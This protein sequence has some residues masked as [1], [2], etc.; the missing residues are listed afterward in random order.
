MIIKTKHTLSLTFAALFSSSIYAADTIKFALTGPYTG[1]S[2]AMGVSSRDGAK[3]AIKKINDA[4]G[5]DV[6]GKK[7]KIEFIERD[8]EGKN[9]RG[10]L[11]AQEVSGMADIA[12]IVG[13]VNTGVVIAGD[14]Y[15]QD[16]K[17]L[18]I[19]TPAAGTASMSQWWGKPEIKDLYIF[20]FSPQDTIQAAMVV[21]QA[22]KLGLKK[23]AIM[24]DSTNYGVSGR[25]DLKKNLEKSGIEIVATEKFNI[26]DKDMSAQITK[27]KASGA[28]AVLIWGIGPEL[29]AVANAMNTLNLK[30]PYI[31]GWTLSMG[32]YL[33]NAGKNADGTLMPQ[34]FVEDA[35]VSKQAADFISNYHKTYNVKRIPSAMS[36]AQGYDAVLILAAAIH[37]AGS[38]DSTKVKDALENL[39]EPVKGIIKTWKQPYA[40][41]DPSNPDSHEAFKINDVIMSSVKDGQVIFADPA[42]KAKL[43]DKL[44]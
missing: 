44:K 43:K 26:G 7:M 32:S 12:A 13:T 35:S 23:V 1:G 6:G 22:K 31:G 29:A 21:E 2:A 34:S 38:T 4:G 8:D 17:K 14:K 25:D 27:I 40:K 37:Q 10:A 36:A 39:K 24:H 11:V 41:W 28:Q 16:A 5:I 18:R 33:D 19:I 30:V 42:D 9:E 15:Y 3:L 20:R